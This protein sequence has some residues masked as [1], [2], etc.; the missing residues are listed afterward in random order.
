[1]AIELTRRL[2]EFVSGLRSADLPAESLPVIHT[3]FTDCIGVM[4]AGRGQPPAQ[5]LKAAL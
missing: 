2:G 4:I 3:G 1:M 5:L